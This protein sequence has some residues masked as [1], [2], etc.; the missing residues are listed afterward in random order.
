LMHGQ[1]ARHWK[2]TII[3]SHTMRGFGWRTIQTIEVCL[4]SDQSRVIMG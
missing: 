3:T 2:L 1:T 4:G